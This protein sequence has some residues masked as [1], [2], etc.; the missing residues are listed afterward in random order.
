MF[1]HKKDKDDYFDPESVKKKVLP[2]LRQL[3]KSLASH[4]NVAALDIS[5][6]LNEHIKELE[7][8]HSQAFAAKLKRVQDEMV[9]AFTSAQNQYKM[10]QIERQLRRDFEEE[11][12]R[13]LTRAFFL[14]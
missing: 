9:W 6:R 7:K 5:Y 8:L 4:Q 12:F 2:I 1:I 3:E 10:S 11:S 13:L 14:S